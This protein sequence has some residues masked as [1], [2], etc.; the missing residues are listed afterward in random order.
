MHNRRAQLTLVGEDIEKVELSRMQD[1]DEYRAC[2]LNE[3]HT[4]TAY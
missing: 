4:R 2:I 1:R 3:G